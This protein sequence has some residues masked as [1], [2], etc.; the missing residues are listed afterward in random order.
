[1]KTKMKLNGVIIVASLALLSMFTL[2]SQATAAEIIVISPITINNG[3]GPQVDPHVDGDV[4]AYTNFAVG[5]QIRYYNFSTGVDSPIPNDGNHD[6]LSDVSAGRIVFTRVFS[7]G[8]EAIMLF[9]T[10]AQGSVPVEVNSSA[11]SQRSDVAIGGDIIAYVDFLLSGDNQTG[12]LV[13]YDLGTDAVTRLT[14][15]F[16]FDGAPAVSSDGSVVVWERRLSSDQFN[17]DVMMAVRTTSGWTIS[18][19]AATETDERNPDTNGTMVVFFVGTGIGGDYDVFW[20]PV[21]G[22][23]AVQLD[24]PGDQH[25][26]A[27]AGDV[28]TFAGL[29]ADNVSTDL[30]IYHLADG[31]L[32]QLTDTPGI[33]ESLSDVT[34][35]PDGRVRVVWQANDGSDGLHNIYGATFAHPNTPPVADAGPDQAIS[36]LGSTVQLDGSGS[37][38]LEGDPMTYQWAITAKPAGSAAVL[39]NATS[40]S[41][42][43]VADLFGTYTISLVVSDPWV[44]STPDTVEMSFTNLKPVADAGPSQSVPVGSTVTLDGTASSDPNGDPLSY[45]WS[46]TS[47]PAGSTATLVNPASAIASFTPDA[48]G[49]YVV[50]LVVND[51]LLDSDPS[52]ATVA[53]T[54]NTETVVETLQQIL[55]LINAIPA[56]D[57]KNANLAKALG[58]KIN[59]VL[60]DIENGH[61]RDALDKLENDILKKTDG[62]AVTGAPDQNDWVMSCMQQALLYDA[63]QRAIAEL[64]LLA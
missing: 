8:R 10:T 41:P 11:I 32:Y 40:S 13:V 64:Q 4:A 55:D 24:L 53:A 56:S 27:I 37:Y 12:E 48:A 3:A 50:S 57:L 31:Q 63:I 17:Y 59:A 30:F 61:Y 58:N 38:D 9:D 33:S 5:G 28:F 2:L 21:S 54:S 34:L 14:N 23:A 47:V 29:A 51:G 62:C 25:S 20:R 52:T 6:Q 46:L 42:T 60:N 49:T 35:L 18:E 19:V 7:D 45:L 43:F 15:D 26:P 36:T 1:M 39:S 44:A 22:G 16:N